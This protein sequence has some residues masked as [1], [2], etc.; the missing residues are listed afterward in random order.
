MVLLHSPVSEDKISYSKLGNE[1][2]P[3]SVARLRSA[4]FLSNTKIYRLKPMLPSISRP[5]S[6]MVRNPRENISHVAV[7]QLVGDAFKFMLACWREVR[8]IS[9]L[10]ILTIHLVD[11]YS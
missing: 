2:T 9:A 7:C 4:P 6:R 5:S 10:Q 8:V 1:L 3:T 11:N